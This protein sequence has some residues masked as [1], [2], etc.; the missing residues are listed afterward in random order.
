MERRNNNVVWHPGHVTR[1]MFES[2]N[3]HRATLLWF[4]GLSGAGKSTLALAVQKQL[5]AAGCMTFV[6]DGDNL[7]HGLCSDL[8]FTQQDR[9]ENIRRTAEVAKLFLNSGCIVL[10]AFISPLVSQREIVRTVVGAEDMLEVF[11][12]CTFDVC[13]ERDP[14]GLYRRALAGEIR[15]FTGVSAPYEEPPAPALTVETAH[16]DLESC[17]ERVI[18]LLI[19]RNVFGDSISPPG[20]QARF[21]HMANAAELAGA[22][23]G[24]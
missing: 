3:G 8:S 7:R 11:C 21:D 14:K 23:Q 6:L 24:D 16:M 1:G 10:A 18:G 12:R 4:T 22:P 15:D 13:A 20:A 17:V 5:H 9:T 2:R 19:R